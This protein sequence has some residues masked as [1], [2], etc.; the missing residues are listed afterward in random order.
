[1]P[2]EFSGVVSI[3]RGP[4]VVFE[5]A[6]GRADRAHGI[7]ATVD[8]LFAM[9]SGSK[10][11]TALA[12]MSLVADG[13]LTLD[14]PAR[15]LLGADLPLI[16]DDVTVEHL[17]GH[18]SGIGDYL[19]EDLDEEPPLKVPVQSLVTSNDFIPA[20]EGFAAKFPSGERF[21]YCNAG[22]VVLA[23]IAERASGASYH[24]L[25]HRRVFDPAG[26]QDTGFLRSDELPGRA[27]VGYLPDGRTNVFHLPVRGNGDGGAYTTVADIRAFWAALDAGRI[28]PAE[29]LALMTTPRHAVG[30][31]R[32]YGLGFWLAGDADRV[33]LEGGDHGVTF[34]TAHDPVT[35]RT[36]TILANS[37]TRLS[38]V[39]AGLDTQVF[40]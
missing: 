9:A 20:L 8:T 35:G 16:P 23:L 2:A 15:D 21:S 29:H 12:V 27:A 5:R 7:A 37:E 36:W 32:R 19:D 4:D 1:M 14:T 13:V 25:V 39:R 3:S 28:V 24:D 31:A 10:G 22:Y 34:M 33:M 18:S 40:G 6:Y 38:G 17:L 11:F 26:M 30:S